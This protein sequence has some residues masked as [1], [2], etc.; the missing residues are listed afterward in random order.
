MASY[1]TICTIPFL[2]LLSACAD[3]AAPLPLEPGDSDLA[4]A[5]FAAFDDP[6]DPFDATRWLPQEHPLGL[7]GFHLANVVPVSGGVRLVLP[8]GTR[9]GG[10]IRSAATL[11]YGSF[12]ARMRTPFAPGSISAFFLYQG[13]A[14]SDELDIEIFND[15]SRRVMFTVWTGGRE[16]QNV[17]TVLPFDPSLGYHDYRIDW[18]PGGVAF[19]VDG[20]VLQRWAKQIPRNQMYLMANAWWPVWLSGNP[21]PAD[22]FLEIDAIRATPR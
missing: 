1:R 11:G 2:A 13:V 6:L 12:E 14:R 9:D 8:A 18:A 17:T 7:G 3:G 5:S 21:A 16:T 20:V 10:E 19:A 4:S 15:G 22:A